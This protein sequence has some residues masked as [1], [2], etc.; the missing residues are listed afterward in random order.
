MTESNTPYSTPNDK[1]LQIL[2]KNIHYSTLISPNNKYILHARII[3]MVS[4]DFLSNKKKNYVGY[5]FFD[6][7]LIS[8]EETFY[9]YIYITNI[10]DDVPIL[11]I[12]HN[13][14]SNI[15]W[16]KDSDMIL[17]CI[18]TCLHASFLTSNKT[19]KYPRELSL[20]DGK[21]YELINN[22][23]C[24][25]KTKNLNLKSLEKK[26]FP[27]ELFN[28]KDN[29]VA[30]RTMPD[31]LKDEASQQD[32][33]Q[34]ISSELYVL[35]LI[36]NTEYQLLKLSPIK[37]FDVSPSGNKVMVEIFTSLSPITDSNGFGYDVWIFDLLSKNSKCI[38]SI[39]KYENE[40]NTKDAVKNGPREI[41]WKGTISDSIVWINTTEEKNQDQ[42][43]ASIQKDNLM[44]CPMSPNIITLE[45]NS[46]KIYETSLR[47][48]NIK[49]DTRGDLWITEKSQRERKTIISLI[50]RIENTFK[51]DKIFSYDSDDLYNIPGYNMCIMNQI[52]SR[53]EIYRTVTNT[54]LMGSAGHSEKGVKPF[55]YEYNLSNQEKQIVWESSPNKYERPIRLINMYNGYLTIFYSSETSTTS[56]IY[57]FFHKK[58]GQRT[59]SN[60]LVQKTQFIKRTQTIINHS[61]EYD[62]LK[63]YKKEL[64]KYKRSDG[65]NLS[66]TLYMPNNLE[67]N[68]IEPNPN[69]K[70][71]IWAYPEEYNS[72]KNTGQIRSSEHTFDY[73]GWSSPLFWLGSGYIVVDDCD[74]PILGTESG[75]KISFIDQLKLNAE[76][77]VSELKRRN[78]IGELENSNIAIGGHSFGAFMV[79]NLLTH[80]KIFKTGIARSGAYNRTLTPFG[81]QFE[82]RNFWKASEL[83]LE[84]SP[85]IHADKIDTPLLLI[86]GQS[87]SNPG[88]YPIQ[89]ERYYEALRG[90]GKEVKILILPY[91][92]HS[93]QAKE[94]ILHML[95]VCDQWLEKYLK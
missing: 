74:M 43:I 35:D 21:P 30:K 86:H 79:A 46:M 22:K 93:Y 19:T 62:T 31:L 42:S 77:I 13:L 28:P 25:C 94:S 80:T 44:Y 12:S 90:L 15:A 29:V 14:I 24:I 50:S 64:I 68:N 45:S 38:I 51:I 39:P 89:S 8:V 61:I 54:I 75:C 57:K 84:I 60:G 69:H 59:Q 76:A 3:D 49:I 26:I 4:I 67:S 63:G 72:E 66:A 1:I 2:D 91:E 23:T 6:N 40:A 5:T 65:I 37:S 78:L 83:Y 27:I 32:F 20:I 36:N 81:F 34:S 82:D 95:N 33:I 92:D 85:F 56:R 41:R 58:F 18:D 87:D 10:H 9:D 52:T 47:I 16:G 11:E 7:N 88:T 53:S 55:I 70:I 73:V 17:Y 71:L 48:R